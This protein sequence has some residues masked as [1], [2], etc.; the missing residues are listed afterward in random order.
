MWIVEV[1]SKCHP[2]YTG[3][4]KGTTRK[5]NVDKFYKKYGMEENKAA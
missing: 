1:C 4:Q 3:T 2:F 5:G